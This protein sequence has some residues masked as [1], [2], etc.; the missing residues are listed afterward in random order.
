M[1]PVKYKLISGAFWLLQSVLCKSE[2]EV[3]DVVF[4]AGL[5]VGLAVFKDDWETQAEK[6][7]NF[8]GGE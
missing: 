3:A 8:L 5:L 7:E 4:G 2:V 1:G 6:A